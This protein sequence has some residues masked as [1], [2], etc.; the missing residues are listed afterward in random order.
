[1]KYDNHTITIE[2]MVL[3]LHDLEPKDY[4]TYEDLTSQLKIEKLG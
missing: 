3:H 1:M 4:V 2:K